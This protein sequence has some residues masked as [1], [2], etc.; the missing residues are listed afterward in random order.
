[1]ILSFS[2]FERQARVVLTVKSWVMVV[3]FLDGRSAADGAGRAGRNTVV[4][5]RANHDEMSWLMLPAKVT[6]TPPSER[7]AVCQLATA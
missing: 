7:C 4:A 5:V 2:E 6:L 1:M 3:P